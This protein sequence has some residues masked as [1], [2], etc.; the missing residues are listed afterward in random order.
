LEAVVDGQMKKRPLTRSLSLGEW[1]THYL[2]LSKLSLVDSL[3]TFKDGLV[4]Q[5]A[6]KEFLMKKP[7]P[8]GFRWVCCRFRWVRGR[9]RR[10]DAHD[11]GY[12]AWCFLVRR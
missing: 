12:E 7:P 4:S 1:E 3:A 11:Y 5:L 9:T 8:P 6:E 2:A 10:L